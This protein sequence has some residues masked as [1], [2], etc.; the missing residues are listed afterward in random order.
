VKV[1]WG[2]LIQF[3]ALLSSLYRG[4]HPW[5]DDS[6]KASVQ[7]TIRPTTHRESANGITW[8]FPPT[9]SHTIRCNPVEQWLTFIAVFSVVRSR[10]SSVSIETR[11]RAG[12][13]GFN[14]L[15]RQRCYFYLRHRV[16]T[17]S[18]ARPAYCPINTRG[19][20]AR[21]WSWPLATI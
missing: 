18:G 21:A 5:H 2:P 9:L 11:L 3:Q 6:M 10:L 20:Q 16:Q 1:F 7:V 4:Q 15:Q 8:H 13:Q 17:G 12:R 14:S 19:K